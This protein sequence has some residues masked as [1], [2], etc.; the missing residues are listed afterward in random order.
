M[1]VNMNISMNNM[2]SY[3][4]QLSQVNSG[5]SNNALSRA[6]QNQGQTGDEVSIS[7]EGR[8]M[9]QM[10]RASEGKEARQAHKAAFMETYSELDIESLDTENMT[11]E[12]IT[13]VLT[14]FET[15]MSDHMH[16]GYTPAS[17]MNSSELE[18]ALNNI[19]DMSSKMNGNKGSYGPPRGG[20]PKGAK[21]G[22]MKP[23]EM[24]SIEESDESD[25]ED[26]ISSLLEAL[27]EQA[28][29]NILLTPKSMDEMMA[30]LGQTSTNV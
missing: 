1:E 18:D 9:S 27:N 21:P 25:E 22:G 15:A 26:L 6:F 8:A 5:Y 20:G 10:M 23:V 28:E 19:K 13:E 29:E 3:I 11:D 14:A 16:Q 7:S 4:S 12:E 24:Q 30:M 17:E 2:N